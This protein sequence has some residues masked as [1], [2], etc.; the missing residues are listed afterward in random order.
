MTEAK[1]LQQFPELSAQLVEAEKLFA[2][3]LTLTQ[4]DRLKLCIDHIALRV[5]DLNTATYWQQALAADSELLSNNKING[6]PIYLYQ[7][8][9]PLFILN[10]AVNIIELPFPNEKRYPQQGWEHIE[11]VLPFLK[12][13]SIE[14][15]FHRAENM[16]NIESHRIILK[17]SCHKA[18]GE[19]LPNPA[20]AIKLTDKNNFTT[21]K[22]HP[23]SIKEIVMS[24]QI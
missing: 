16:L 5:N 6:R 8:P 13:E 4:L 1:L 3:I 12:N 7:L 15:W 17:K 10:Q 23:F 24:E 18:D 22:L 21:I 19:G 20:L 11:L 14:Q 9:Q 2:Q